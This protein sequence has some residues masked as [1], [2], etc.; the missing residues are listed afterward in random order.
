[1]FLQRQVRS[2]LSLCV[3]IHPTHGDFGGFFCA[4][5]EKVAAGPATRPTSCAHPRVDGEQSAEPRGTKHGKRSESDATP[6]PI[7]PL[8]TVAA[9]SRLSWFMDWFGLLSDALQAC[10][11]RIVSVS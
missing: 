6:N 2:A 5:F 4:L 1:M 10:G 9:S 3:R 7:P 11:G 8:L